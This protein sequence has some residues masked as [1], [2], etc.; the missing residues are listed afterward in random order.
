MEGQE[1]GSGSRAKAGGFQ[2]RATANH[3]GGGVVNRGTSTGAAQ[4]VLARHP[5]DV[6]GALVVHEARRDEQEIGQAVEIFHRGGGDR[7][8]RPAGE[9]DHEALGPAADRAGEV[10]RR[11]GGRAARQHEGAQARE[12]AVEPVDLA[13]QP[14]DLG[15]D[16][17]ERLVGQGLAGLRRREVGA[18]VE[19]VVL[20]AAEHRVELVRGGVQAGEAEARIGLVDGAVGRDPE[21]VLRPA[22]AGR[23]RGR[24]AVAGAGVDAVQNH[25]DGC[26]RWIGSDRIAEARGRFRQA[27]SPSGGSGPRRPGTGSRPGSSRL[28]P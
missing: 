20:D 27:P 22:R 18:E 6:E 13:L 19:E 23:E 15:I 14:L 26:L 9:L 12:V 16:D 11:R 8:V 3:A 21:V 28:R 2:G 5:Q 1:H 7:L 4:P 25:H 10:E 24:A 17:A